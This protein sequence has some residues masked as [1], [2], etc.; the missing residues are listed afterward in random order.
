MP[1]SQVTKHIYK[2]SLTAR[3]YT[4]ILQGFH[5]EI[6]NLVRLIFQ[7]EINCQRHAIGGEHIFDPYFSVL[8]SSY[9]V[10]GLADWIY[11]YDRYDNLIIYLEFHHKQTFTDLCTC[12]YIALRNIF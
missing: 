8:L 2:Y 5:P 7:M 11:I 1:W 9:A 3:N 4:A 10:C 6:L 12:L